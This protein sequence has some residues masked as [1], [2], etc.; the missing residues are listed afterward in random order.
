MKTEDEAGEIPRKLTTQHDKRA[1]TASSFPWLAFAFA[2]GASLVIF[3]ISMMLFL[4]TSNLAK[5]GNPHADGRIPLPDKVTTTADTPKA[6]ANPDGKVSGAHG[7]PDIGEMVSRLEARVKKP[8]ATVNDIVMLARSYRA[9]NREEEALAL[10]RRA[11]TIEPQNEQ[12]QL[13]VASA[14]IGAEDEK[15]HNE[16]EEVVDAILKTEPEK[17]EALWLKSLALIHRHEIGTARDT[18]TKLSGLVGENADAKK[19]VSELLASLSQSSQDT[20]RE[21]TSHS[22]TAPV[23]GATASDEAKK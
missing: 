8:D 14:L 10:Y 16:G 11:R 22:D 7:T 9:L 1:T 3:G 19:A 18:L 15:T 2:L 23:A 12:L 21:P 4:D 13:V 6:D 20:V 5:S 17:P